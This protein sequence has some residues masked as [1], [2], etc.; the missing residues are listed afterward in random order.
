[1]PV[2]QALGCS[3]EERQNGLWNKRLLLLTPRYRG[4]RIMAPNLNRWP[5]RVDADTADAHS[6]PPRPREPCARAGGA[7]PKG[8]GGVVDR[9]RGTLFG[10][11]RKRG[12]RG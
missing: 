1:M 12:E 3:S 6:H 5:E 7:R 4:A 2:N 9:Q 8:R 10:R 11:A